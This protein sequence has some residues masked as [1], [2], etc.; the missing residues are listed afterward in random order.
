M[1]EM[2]KTLATIQTSFFIV[3][4]MLVNKIEVHSGLTLIL[5]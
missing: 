1:K 2:E 4:Y 5:K 3:L